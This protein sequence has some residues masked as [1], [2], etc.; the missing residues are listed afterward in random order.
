MTLA[1]GTAATG[2]LE[3]LTV[4]ARDIKAETIT[5]GDFEQS[6]FGFA[7]TEDLTFSYKGQSKEYTVN[8][9][10]G[11]A[12]TLTADSED[13]TLSATE[14]TG[15]QSVNV[16]LPYSKYI[17]EKSYTL[18][19]SADGQASKTLTIT[20]QS[21]VDPNQSDPKG[22]VATGGK[23]TAEGARA[24]VRTFDTFKYGTFVWT[25][26]EVNI[27]NGFFSID[28]W[29]QDGINLLLRVGGD[30]ATNSLE[31]QGQLKIGDRTV[32]FGADS[33]WNNGYNSKSTFTPG[34]L[35][36][37]L[38]SLKLEILPDEMDNPQGAPQTKRLSRKIWINDVL[39][40]DNSEMATAGTSQGV[41]GDVWQSGST[42]PGLQ[43]LFGID[44]L[45]HNPTGTMTI[46]S[47]E[48]IPYS[49]E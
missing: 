34:I 20:Q 38:K 8:A 10:A 46:D 23:L 7:P 28:N 13:V 35:I 37:E 36:N 1:D 15:T 5:L 12:W 41:G 45:D 29:G 9:S 18:T 42:H 4:A 27:T 17:Y 25:F 11:T 39:V 33:G 22:M 3:S 40:L 47:F 16:T 30:G 31:C 14:G 49:A 19:L 2:T 43:Y 44:N 24:M 6:E 32:S 48:Y 26:S 21:C